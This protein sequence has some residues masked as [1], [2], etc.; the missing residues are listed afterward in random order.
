MTQDT[1]SR[2]RM[3]ESKI[4]IFVNYIYYKIISLHLSTAKQIQLTT[5]YVCFKEKTQ[6]ELQKTMQSGKSIVGHKARQTDSYE[7]TQEREGGKR[8]VYPLLKLLA[9]ERNKARPRGGCF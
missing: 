5:P 9:K 4:Q 1:F 8:G 7:K 6:L 2:E 3:G